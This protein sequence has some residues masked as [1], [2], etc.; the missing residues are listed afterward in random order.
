MWKMYARDDAR[1]MIELSQNYSH[2]Q[3]PNQ[4]DTPNVIT[5][6]KSSSGP[7]HGTGTTA[8]SRA[9]ARPSSARQSRTATRRSSAGFPTTRPTRETAGHSLAATQLA[10]NA[11]AAVVMTRAT[12]SMS[13][14]SLG[15]AAVAWRHAW[16]K[17]L[18]G[19]SVYVPVLELEQTHPAGQDLVGCQQA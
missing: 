12:L 17:D 15:S 13:M 9:C 4:H 19:Y 5:P 3:D 6:S 7:M 14:T 8:C 2:P 1:A 10:S 18:I 11:P 16:S